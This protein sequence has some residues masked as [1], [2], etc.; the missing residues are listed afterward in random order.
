MRT[1]RPTIDILDACTTTAGTTCNKGDIAY[2]K[3]GNTQPRFWHFEEQPVAFADNLM[4]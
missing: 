4:Y 2:A 1:S 3:M